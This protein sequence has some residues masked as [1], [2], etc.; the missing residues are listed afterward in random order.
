MLDLKESVSFYT[1]ITYDERLGLYKAKCPFCLGE[2]ETFI[3]DNERDA[4]VCYGCGEM[5]NMDRFL[6][7]KN[8]VEPIEY[9]CATPELIPIYKAAQDFYWLQIEE[10]GNPGRK[11]FEQRGIDERA[12]L[13][14]GLG[15]APY[16]HQLYDF[17]KDRG[18]DEDLIIASKLVKVSPDTGEIYDFFRNRVMFPIYDE[19]NDVIAFGGRILQEKKEE[20]KKAA[21]KYINSAD[22]PLFSKRKI[23]YGYP[24]KIPKGRKRGMGI[25]ICEGYMDLIAL[26]RA[27]VLDSAAVLGTAL[28][29]EHAKRIANDYKNVFLALDSDNAGMTAMISSIKV[30]RDYGLKV[31]IMNYNTPEHPAKDADELISKHGKKALLEVM[32]YQTKADYYLAKHIEPIDQFT[33]LMVKLY[34]EGF[35]TKKTK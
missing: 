35:D 27:D 32:R 16:G 8:G 21:P 4:Y 6:Q 15:Y 13:E 19:N 26:K 2:T 31:Y 10:E 14:F 18:Y 17:F 20:G 34:R 25:V 1:K 28:T 11:Y 29:D 23:L 33:D 3:V 5:G 24:Y 12:I 7:K 22:S 30:L 9:E